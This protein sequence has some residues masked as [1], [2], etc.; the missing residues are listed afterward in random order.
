M[1]RGRTGSLLILRQIHCHKPNNS[2]LE[3]SQRDLTCH[4][5]SETR[6]MLLKLWHVPTA[7]LMT[8]S[9]LRA[10]PKLWGYRSEKSTTTRNTSVLPTEKPSMLLVKCQLISRS[11]SDHL[12]KGRS[13]SVSST[14][15]VPWLCPSSWGWSSCNKRKH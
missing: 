15:S 9:Y 2:D 1:K 14:S 3:G 12:P 11:P 6:K 5:Y 7:G 4:S 8:T 13:Q 10:S